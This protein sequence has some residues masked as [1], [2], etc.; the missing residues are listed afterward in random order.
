MLV[1]QH[2]VLRRF[3]Y[4][5]SRISDLVDQPKPFTLLGQPLVL[6][7]D[8]AADPAVALDRC[9]HRSARLSQGV[10][11][12]GCIRCPYHGW[13]FDRTGSCVHV[14]QLPTQQ[15]IPSTYAVTAFQAQECYGYA[16]VCLGDPLT[17]IPEL[18]EVTDPSF[19]QIQQ[20]DEVW[21]CAGLRLMEN[22]FD[23]AHPHFVHAKTFGISQ[24]PVPPRLDAF[25]EF[26]F[27]LRM[28]YVFP[29]FN[30]DLQQ[31]NLQMSETTTVRIS[32]ATWFMPFSRKLKITYPNGRIHII[33]TA[34]TPIDDHR[35]QV[36]QFCLRND[37][38][39]EVSAASIIAFDRDV[40]LEDQRILEGTDPDMPLSLKAEQQMAT[41][42]P[43]IVMRRRLAALLKAHA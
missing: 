21:H 13:E 35:S 42:K 39:S 6:W 16:W 12:A 29:V 34:A 41:D 8:E 1:T 2:P 4:P 10:V 28:R 5:V 40:T 38:E 33:F 27:G 36:M 22:S 14:P 9:Y 23:N 30:S 25:E 17:S 11:R 31:Q 3:W 43:G 26:E 20:F 32:D 24:D 19:R 18:P 15:A 37:T 7:L